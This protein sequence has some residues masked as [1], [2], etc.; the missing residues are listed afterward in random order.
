MK[1]ILLKSVPKVG[2]KD[3]VVE[4]APGYAAHAL[5]PKKLAIPATDAALQALARHTQSVAAEK[6]IQYTLLDK[7][8]QELRDLAVE[9]PV[10]ANEQGNLFSKVHTNDIAAFLMNKHRIA[11]DPKL[12]HIPDGALKHLGTY[13]VTVTEGQYSSTFS[14]TLTT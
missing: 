12:L 8:V 2:H 10:K 13:T 3:A 1:V 7:A 5:F 9:M 4:V 11:I 6:Q 14:I